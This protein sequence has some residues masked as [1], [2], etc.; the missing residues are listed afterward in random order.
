MLNCIEKQYAELME[1]GSK[2]V[3]AR[4][5]HGK[6][7]TICARDSLRLGTCNVV[8]GN[9]MHFLCFRTML[10]KV[11]L[12]NASP[13]AT[14]IEQR[15]RIYYAFGKYKTLAKDK[16]VVAFKAAKPPRRESTT[17]VV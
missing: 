15:M 4:V 7:A 1:R 14:C 9:V 3:E 10:K 2:T 8:V 5:N 11:G 12:H 17:P 6:A 16:G 13:D